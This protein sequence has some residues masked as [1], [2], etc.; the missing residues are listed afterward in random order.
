MADSDSAPTIY[1]T[2]H[3][4]DPTAAIAWLEKAFGFKTKMNVPDESGGVAHAELS[5]G[6]GMIMLGSARKDMG[7]VSPRDLPA[8]HQAIYVYVADP[9]A[10]FEQAK[11]AGAE[12][13]R[14]PID[15]DHGSRDYG[16]KDLEGHE[17][18][19]GTYRPAP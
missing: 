10:H 15:T 3:Y 1:P 6:A 7:W 5:L 12:I 14:E 11:A 13:T 9:D 19:F 18:W 17:W 8:L 4:N 2:L 16:A